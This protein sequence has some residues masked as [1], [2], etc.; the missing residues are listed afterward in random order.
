M[1]SF[2]V[3]P[4]DGSFITP[5]DI[6]QIFYNPYDK[7]LQYYKILQDNISIIIKSSAI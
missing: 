2:S 7:I 6:F 3:T 1:R 5:T 4:T